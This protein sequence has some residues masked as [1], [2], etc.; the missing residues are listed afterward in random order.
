MKKFTRLKIKQHEFKQ[1]GFKYTAWL[2]YG[3]A[4][5]GTRIRKQFQERGEAQAWASTQE[6]R[7][8]NLD[9]TSRPVLTRLDQDQLLTAELAISR[10][11][12][13]GTLLDAVEHFLRTGRTVVI[14]I[15]LK[16]AIEKFLAFKSSGGVRARTVKQLKSVLA[17]FSAKFGEDKFLHEVT[18]EPYLYLPQTWLRLA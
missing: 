7:H 5:D 12:G 11:N 4:P 14:K 15:A 18:T 17:L 3:Y 13:K 1:N 2:V 6:I 10:L 9:V 16:D 8:A